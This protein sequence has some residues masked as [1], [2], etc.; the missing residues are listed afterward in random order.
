V[1]IMQA[2]T[3]RLLSNVEYAVEWPVKALIRHFESRLFELATTIMMLGIGLFVVLWPRSIE[4]GAF[5][6]LLT[7]V[8]AET[9]VGVY[10]TIGVA[11]IAALIANGH[12]K[13]YGPVIRA[14]GALVGAVV[15]AQMAAALVLLFEVNGTPPSVG[16]PVYSVLAFFELISMYRALARGYV[17]KNSGKTW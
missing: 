17:G 3:M 11:R 10:V 13:F 8:S 1:T 16:I 2:Q 14:A 9:I 12:W 4:A 15:W 7:V 6:Y 5:R